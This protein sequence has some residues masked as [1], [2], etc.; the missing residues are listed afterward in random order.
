MD[1]SHDSSVSRYLKN[2]QTD[3]RCCN[4]TLNFH[5]QRIKCFSFPTSSTGCGV[6]RFLNYS[7][8]DK[9][10]MASQKSFKLNFPGD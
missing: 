2:L 8:S 5:Q 10:E 7:H 3:L 1:R 6:N 9:D 4:T